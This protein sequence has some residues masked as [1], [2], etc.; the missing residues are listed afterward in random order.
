MNKKAFTLVE[1]LAVIIILGFILTIATINVR[2]YINQANE[3]S[4]NILVKSVEEATELYLADN[5]GAYPQLNVVG[6]T[7][8][9]YLYSLINNNYID[10]H[11]VDERTD[12]EIP[13]TTLIK[14]TV[15]E[16]DKLDI[17]FPYEEN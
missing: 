13:G 10:E 9:I 7:F 16:N 17:V 14:I 1:L 12:K 8:T 15:L 3:T 4:Y 5:M 11:L 6:S 2:N